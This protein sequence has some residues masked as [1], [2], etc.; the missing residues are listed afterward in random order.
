MFLMKEYFIDS[1]SF[2]TIGLTCK[3]NFKLCRQVL[4]DVIVFPLSVEIEAQSEKMLEEFLKVN[5][6][7]RYFMFFNESNIKYGLHF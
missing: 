1:E 4:N 7:L 6:N 3:R 2:W 5:K